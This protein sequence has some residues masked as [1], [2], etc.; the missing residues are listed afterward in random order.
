MNMM[1]HMAI[2]ASARSWKINDV[3]GTS[4][5]IDTLRCKYVDLLS[6]EK[7]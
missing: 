7:I 6:H 3:I 1:T 4:N 5:H 2:K